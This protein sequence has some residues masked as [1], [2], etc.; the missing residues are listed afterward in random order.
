LTEF[1]DRRKARIAV[2]PGGVHSGTDSWQVELWLTNVG[3]S[4]ARRVQVWLEDEEGT[5]Q[6]EKQRLGRPLMSG[7]ES[8][9]VRLQVPRK[10]RDS[11]VVS[12]VRT[13]RDGRD[14]SLPKDVS[15]QRIRLPE[16]RQELT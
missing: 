3:Q 16:L 10:D 5:P 7:N 12:P 8:V 9:L 2:D 11:L 14:V 13:W 1:R 4:H 6:S 15:E